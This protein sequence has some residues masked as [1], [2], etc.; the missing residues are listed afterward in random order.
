MANRYYSSWNKEINSRCRLNDGLY[1]NGFSLCS[2]PERFLNELS[3]FD[4][5]IDFSD[6]HLFYHAVY[7]G[8]YEIAEYLAESLISIDFDFALRAWAFSGFYQPEKKQKMLKLLIDHGANIDLDDGQIIVCCRRINGF[9]YKTLF[10]NGYCLNDHRDI[11]G[12]IWQDISY[13]FKNNMSDILLCEESIKILLENNIDV[14][15]LTGQCLYNLLEIVDFDMD[16]ILLLEKYNVN[17]ELLNEIVTEPVPSFEILLDKGVEYHKLL[18]LI[19][20][21]E[22]F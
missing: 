18:Y 19:Y 7:E 21:K 17:F 1:N 9:F 16:Y 10:D 5:D 14:D 20:Y 4:I 13:K 6:N 3:E 22:N 15:Q 2:D 11:H 8:N 12:D